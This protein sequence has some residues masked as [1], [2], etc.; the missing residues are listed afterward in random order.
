MV[1]DL[2]DMM[3]REHRQDQQSRVFYELSA[4][5]LNLLRYPPTP[6]QFS[7]EVST[8]SR[9]QQ[10]QR[11]PLTQITPAGFASLLLGISL[12]LMLCGSITFFIGFLLM[13]WVLG[14]VMVFYVVGIVSSLAMLG[15]AIFF[16][17]LSPKKGVPA[18]KLL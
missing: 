7:D 4:L 10:P 9:R 18:W 17:T 12:S 2:N 3:R 1:L 5:I 6:I 15:R 16:H 14:L 13:P 11:P 8:S